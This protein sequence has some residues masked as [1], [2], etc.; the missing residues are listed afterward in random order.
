MNNNIEERFRINFESVP[1]SKNSKILRDENKLQTF[2]QIRSDYLNKFQLNI[3]SRNAMLI[4]NSYLF[5]KL[6]KTKK[7]DFIK[8]L[9]VYDS[10]VYL[11]AM[12]FNV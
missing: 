12:M 1:T 2:E 4:G 10:F 8:I 6:I 7:S 9:I 11:C 5:Y 3:Y